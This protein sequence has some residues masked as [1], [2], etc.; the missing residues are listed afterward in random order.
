MFICFGFVILS[1]FHRQD[2]RFVSFIN[3]NPIIKIIYYFSCLCL[4]GLPFLSGFFSK[5]FIIEKFIEI[6]TE[7]FFVVFLLIFIRIS[8]YYRIKLL[9]LRKYL[10]SY[11]IKEKSYIGIFRVFFIGLVIIVLINIYIR[12][13]FRL[14]LEVVSFKI[15]IYFLILVFFFLRIITNLN[16]KFNVYDKIKNFK[17]I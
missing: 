4:A 8:I 11:R 14:R 2:K 6:N 3:L 13:V 15:S 17:E 9:R 1:S 16:L 12:V 10:F 5:D 7:I